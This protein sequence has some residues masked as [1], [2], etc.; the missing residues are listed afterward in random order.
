MQ[1]YSADPEVNRF[2]ERSPSDPVSSCKMLKV[3][4]LSRVKGHSRLLQV[5]PYE[6]KRFALSRLDLLSVASCQAMFSFGNLVELKCHAGLVEFLCHQL[7]LFEG[8]IGIRVPW[9][10]TV[11]G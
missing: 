5:K 1:Q 10:N 4:T 11:G 7:R 2:G 6:L 3:I 8:H 9:I